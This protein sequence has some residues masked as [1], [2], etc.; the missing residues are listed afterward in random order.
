LTA[1]ISIDISDV[2]LV[3]LLVAGIAALVI[4]VLGER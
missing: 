1:H 2:A 3:V 4:H